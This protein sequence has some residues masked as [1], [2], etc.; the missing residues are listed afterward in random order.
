MPSYATVDN[1][2]GA[3][4]Q[5]VTMF[6]S[7]TEAA[8]AQQALNLLGADTTNPIVG[9]G[10]TVLGATGAPVGNILDVYNYSGSPPAITLGA[11]AQVIALK[12]NSAHMVTGQAS[13]DGQSGPLSYEVLIG[14]NA[15]DTFH[16]AG[17]SGTI[18]AG[19][20]GGSGQNTGAKGNVIYTDSGNVDVFTGTGKDT[21]YLGSGDDTLNAL[22]SATLYG[23]GLSTNPGAVTISG[24]H[25]TYV[26]GAGT[27]ESVDAANAPVDFQFSHAS[28]GGQYSISGFDTANDK[29]DLFGYS[30]GSAGLDTT[31]SVGNT[32]IDLHDGTKITVNGALTQSD[33]HYN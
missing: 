1:P 30:S 7:T 21:I 5:T 9:T 18:I 23:G 22:G 11:G 32:I 6:L 4:V 28:P 13:L 16:A 24:G 8:I 27:Y 20:A 12:D 17:G 29:I 2:G 3:G 14:N 15:N 19:D 10:G 26:G 31:T 33:I 25:D